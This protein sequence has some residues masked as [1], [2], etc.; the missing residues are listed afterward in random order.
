[1]DRRRDHGHHDRLRCYDDIVSGSFEDLFDEH[2]GTILV[3]VTIIGIIL[4]AQNGA[5]PDQ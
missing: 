3:V 2:L 5:T 1:M 4:A